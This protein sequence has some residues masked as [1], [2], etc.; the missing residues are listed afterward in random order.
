[1]AEFRPKIHGRPGDIPFFNGGRGKPSPGE[2]EAR[3]TILTW[4]MGK[5]NA[6]V[7]IDSRT[8]NVGHVDRADFDRIYRRLLR[9]FQNSPIRGSRAEVNKAPRR[10]GRMP[11]KY[12]AVSE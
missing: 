1:M 8:P 10:H 11:E 2:A 3:K 4:L 6:A 9:D 7:R 5:K 12:R